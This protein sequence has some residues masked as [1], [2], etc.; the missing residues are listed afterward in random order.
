MT[1]EYDE[2]GKFFTDVISKTPVRATVQTTRQ[3]LEG[4]IHVRRGERI[5]DELDRDERFLAMT[6]VS[7]FGADGQV[8]FEAPF[9]AVH[10]SQIVWVRPHD[11][12][13]DG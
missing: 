9:L 5:K 7:V 4:E 6:A 13:S 12:P 8:E 10:R 11:E 1:I 2:K 3:L